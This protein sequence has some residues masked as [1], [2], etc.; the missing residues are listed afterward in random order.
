[1][2]N[3]FPEAGCL[4]LSVRRSRGFVP[5]CVLTP[6]CR[7]GWTAEACEHLAYVLVHDFHGGSGLLGVN[8]W[9]VTNSFMDVLKWDTSEV[10]LR[11]TLTPRVY[12][13][14]RTITLVELNRF[15]AR[16]PAWRGLAHS[17]D[18]IEVHPKSL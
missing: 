15:G 16:F 3:C 2:E 18:V 6:R 4:H 5:R 1:M 17:A 12:R 11:T 14:R 9:E 8:G 13:Q 10:E 7:Q